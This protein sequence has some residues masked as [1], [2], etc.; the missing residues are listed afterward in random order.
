MHSTIALDAAFVGG[1][2]SAIVAVVAF[3][4]AAG[5]KR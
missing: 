5:R 3:A 4:S 1:A 2:C